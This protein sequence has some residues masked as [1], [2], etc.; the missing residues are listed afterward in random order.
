MNDS[1]LDS[2]HK[3]AQQLPRTL[4]PNP[5]LWGRVEA[6]LTDGAGLFLTDEEPSLQPARPWWPIA[7]LTLLGVAVAT[8]VFQSNPLP[9]A[10][11]TG[12]PDP[13]GQGPAQRSATLPV[14]NQMQTQLHQLLDA[15]L[16]DLPDDVR[17]TVIENLEVIASAREEIRQALEQNPDSPLLHSLYLNSYAN[18]RTLLKDVEAMA[19]QTKRRT[20]L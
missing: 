9:P 17:A 16:G 11:A 2:L 8:L 5:N 12:Q 15:Q 1:P 10:I 6:E 7:A 19:R 13:T 18:E 14:K 3:R 4:E 20:Y